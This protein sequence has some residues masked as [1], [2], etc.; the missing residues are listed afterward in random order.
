MI[1]LD[2]LVGRR[3]IQSLLKYCKNYNEALLVLINAQFRLLVS[4]QFKVFIVHVSPLNWVSIYSERSDD[5]AETFEPG[6]RCIS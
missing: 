6:G 4:G 2:G 3:P 5:F 1:S